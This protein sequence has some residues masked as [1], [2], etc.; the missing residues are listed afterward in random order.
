ME[1]YATH[2]GLAVALAVGLLVG[3]EREQTRDE[4]KASFAGVRTYPIFALLGAVSML[5]APWLPVVTLLAVIVLVAISYS[6]TVKQ[7]DHGV[8]T[9]A[10]VIATF[11]LGALAEAHDEIEP[12]SERLIL[13]AALGVAMTF[14]LSAK[15]LLHRIASRVSKDDL[16]AS[17]KFLIVAVIVLPLLPH[18]D[19]GPLG[20]I[21][22]FNVGLMIVTI[23]ALSFLGYIAMRWLGPRR[24]VL[25]GAALGGLVSSTAVTVSFSARTKASPAL[26]P[27]AA[28]AI[29]IASAIMVVRV[30]VLVA[31]TA[32]ELLATLAIVLAG[33]VLGAVAAGLAVFRRDGVETAEP[34]VKNPFELASAI[35]FGLVFGAVLLATKAAKTYL[36]DRGLYLASGLAG[37]TDVDAITLSTAQLARSG[38]SENVATLAIA[39]AVAVNTI[40]KTGLAFGLGGV[41]LG[42]RAAI[43]GVAIIAGGAIGLVIAQI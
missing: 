8:T 34:E 3:L 41:R 22:P 10:S 6:A 27:V 4:R 15:P 35:K 14:L 39:L 13:V 1:A 37:T 28:G 5:L 30:G 12:M 42:L 36:G 20:A 17:L 40:V 16:Y 26:A 31:L 21:D 2:L 19:V 29:A 7:G 9:E 11:L 23:S 33:M 24:G 32:P 18:R 43:V 25:V 38:T